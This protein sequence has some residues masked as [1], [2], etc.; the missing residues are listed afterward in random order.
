MNGKKPSMQLNKEKSSEK[1]TITQKW[2]DTSSKVKIAVIVG[3]VTV[4]IAVSSLFFT[5]INNDINNNITPSVTVETSVEKG[6][7]EEVTQEV[8]VALEESIDNSMEEETNLVEPVLSEEAIEVNEESKKEVIETSIQSDNIETLADGTFV[9]KNEEG[10]YIHYGPTGKM[11]SK[12]S[13]KGSMYANGTY[14]PRTEEG[15]MLAD[16]VLNA[17]KYPIGYQQTDEGFR[18]LD[19]GGTIHEYDKN[20]G[21]LEGGTNDIDAVNDLLNNPVSVEYTNDAGSTE[22][23]SNGTILRRDIN[24]NIISTTYE[25][26]KGNFVT[27][28][29]VGIKSYKDANGNFL[30]YADLIDP[31]TGEYM[32][33]YDYIVQDE[34]M[35]VVKN[36]YAVMSFEDGELTGYVIKLGHD[37]EGSF[38]LDQARGTII[39]SGIC[40]SVEYEDLPQIQEYLDRAAALAEGKSK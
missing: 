39:G 9:I 31:L 13:G 16:D 34:N 18:I 17:V 11:L 10:G 23:L 30:G 20:G 12:S 33:N 8:S 26:D 37:N 25:D 14:V 19:M 5:G 35:L 27:T 24:K 32:E 2:Q 36:P 4:F 6:R 38:A 3:G 1:V 15:K 22:T 21:F 7:L 28:S 29:L 40:V